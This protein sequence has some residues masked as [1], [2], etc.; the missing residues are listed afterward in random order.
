MWRFNQTYSLSSPG[1]TSKTPQWYVMDEIGSAL[2]HNNHP[3][4]K[5]SP[6]FFSV[7]GR[8]YSLIWPIQDIA[9]GD[10]CTRNFVH[11][12]HAKETMNILN[13]RLRAYSEEE[14]KITTTSNKEEKQESVGESVSVIEL[15]NATFKPVT[16]TLNIYVDENLC[17]NFD[18]NIAKELRVKISPQ[19]TKQSDINVLSLGSTHVMVEGEVLPSAELFTNKDYLQNYFLYRFGR[20]AE[21]LAF[22]HILPMDLVD[23]NEEYHQCN[24]V[25][26]WLVKPVDKRIIFFENFVTSQYARVVRMCETGSIAVTR[27]MWSHC[28]CYQFYHF[29]HLNEK[30]YVHSCTIVHNH[31]NF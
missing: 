11:Q 20:A 23:F 15:A 12:I 1:V 27:C 24:T 19:Q 31:K 25:Q 8:A 22:N 5:C 21:W 30:R 13:L 18:Q 14:E 3:N 17:E 9:V 29:I 7:L 16:Q 26:Y 4:M 10:M 2:F 6:F 28:F